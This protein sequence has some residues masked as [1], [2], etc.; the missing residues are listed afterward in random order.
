MNEPNSRAGLLIRVP[1]STSNLGPGFDTL[2]LALALYN[3]F[4]VRPLETGPSRLVGRGTCVGLT[5]ADSVCLTMMDRVAELVGGALPP[6]E[7]TAIGA[8]P[9]GVGLGSSASACV[10]GAL[11]ANRLLGDP[12]SRE[13][14]LTPL[15]EAEGHPDNVTPSLLGGLTATVVTDEGAL[16]RVYPPAPAWRVA[17]LIPDYTLSTAAARKA[18]PRKVPRAD[19]VFNLQRLPF[20]L[21]ALVEGNAAQLRRVLADRLHERHRGKKIK[22]YR[23]IRKAALDAGAAAVFISGAGPAMAALCEGQES[24]DAVVQAMIRV[25]DGAKFIATGLALRPDLEGARVAE[26]E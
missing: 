23:K 3:D 2:G 16:A 1:A 21:E 15:V 14:L 13:E 9:L 20:V 22:R 6:V 17:L 4:V 18:L 24:A 8:V 10:A 26:A 5:G 12:L 11:A 19:A 25:T 7:V